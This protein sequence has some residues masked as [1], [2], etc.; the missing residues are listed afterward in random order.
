MAVKKY[1]IVYRRIGER[2]LQTHDT[3]SA[4]I[5]QKTLEAL[6]GNRFRESVEVRIN[7]KKVET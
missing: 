7:G 5:H 6:K 1:T 3:Y 2:K 4:E